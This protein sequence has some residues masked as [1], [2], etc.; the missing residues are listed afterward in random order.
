MA[1]TRRVSRMRWIWVALFLAVIPAGAGLAQNVWV[2]SKDVKLTLRTGA[3]TQYRI[4]GGLT[5]G[6]A[7]TILSLSD[8]WTYVRTSDG[9]DG[10]VAAGFLGPEPPA[11]VALEK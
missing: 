3:G 11:V 2:K 1:S 4:I 8:G 10:W 9:K 5:T 6:D 7:V